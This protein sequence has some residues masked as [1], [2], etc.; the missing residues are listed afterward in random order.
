MLN[1][2]ANHPHILG[3]RDLAF[4]PA[5]P[6][7]LVASSGGTVRSELVIWNSRPSVCQGAGM[8]DMLQA[9]PLAGRRIFS[10]CLLAETGAHAWHLTMIKAWTTLWHQLSASHSLCYRISPRIPAYHG[11]TRI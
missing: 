8:P 1:L 9:L 5:A 3:M 4:F 7:R 11:I 2:P 6:N 10:L